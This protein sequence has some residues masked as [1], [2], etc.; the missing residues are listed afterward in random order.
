MEVPM[1]QKLRL[2]TVISLAV[3]VLTPL[4]FSAPVR[5]GTITLNESP[6]EKFGALYFPFRFNSAPLMWVLCET[7]VNS[8]GCVN[9]LVSDVVCVTNNSAGEGVAAMISDTETSLSLGNL[10]PD[11]PCQVAATPPIFLKETGQPQ[12]LSGSGIP[13]ILPTGAPGPLIM[14]VATSDLDPSTTVTSDTLQILT[15]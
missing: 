12:V 4:A 5:I 3:L 15:Q 14:V 9:G 8:T 13:T 6:Y 10:P 7:G 11:F 1:L 2:M